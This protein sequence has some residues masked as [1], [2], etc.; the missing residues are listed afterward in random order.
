MA[1]SAG[2]E[3]GKARL[4]LTAVFARRKKD[5]KL[6]LLQTNAPGG[7]IEETVLEENSDRALDICAVLK[8]TKGQFGKYTDAVCYLRSSKQPRMKFA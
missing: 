6:V 1:G 2:K 7:P 4:L 5:G 3:D 8:R